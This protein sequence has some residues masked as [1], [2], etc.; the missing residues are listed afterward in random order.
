MNPSIWTRIALLRSA[1]ESLAWWRGRLGDGFEAVRPYLVPCTGVRATGYLCPTTGL[2]LQVREKRDGYVAFP[3]GENAEDADDIDLVWDDVQAWR[4]DVAALGRGISD[5]LG[6]EAAPQVLGDDGRIGVCRLQGFRR[7][8][9]L[10]LAG[11]GTEAILACRNLGANQGTGCVVSPE[12]HA[13]VAELLGARYVAHLVMP[14]CLAIEGDKIVGNCQRICDSVARDMT[15]LELKEHLDGRI[16]TVGRE[17]ADIE[18]ENEQ[19]KQNL[20]A[21]L[22]SIARQVEPEFFQWIFVILGTGSVSAAARE[23]EMANSTFDERLKKY[24]KRGGLYATLFAMVGVRRKGMGEKRVER[25]NELFGEHQGPEVAAEAD[26]LHA[27]LDG[28]EDLSASNWEGMRNEL[29][30]VVKEALPEE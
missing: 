29:I 20:A 12:R 10:I 17:F 5:A 8:V 16:D 23:L 2:R 21:V 13:G 15:N 24:V 11:D 9:H 4:L 28:L 6:F 27:L 3:T 7:S 25:F 22:A 1:N 14:E 26:V 19:L 30:E 18:R